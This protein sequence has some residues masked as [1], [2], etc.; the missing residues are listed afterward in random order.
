ML[1][2]NHM[3]H[4]IHAVVLSLL[5]QGSMGCLWAEDIS[6][7]GWRLWP[8]RD[9]VWQNDTLFLPS[10]ANL[11]DMP[12]NPPTGGWQALNDQQGIPVTLPSTVEEHYWG[13]FGTRPYAHNEAQ[14]G[15]GTSFQ[16]GNY[17]GVSWWWRTV[18]IPKF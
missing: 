13:A 17:L 8:D 14:R 18:Q 6:T 7:G 5:F 4:L 16:N 2:H 3:K 12:V 9:A 1:S 15:P 11:H 10:E